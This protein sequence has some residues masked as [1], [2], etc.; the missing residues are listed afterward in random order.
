MN[1]PEWSFKSKENWD[2]EKQAI[3]PFHIE[4]FQEALRD[5]VRAAGTLAK[6][7]TLKCEA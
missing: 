4:K 3:G 5:S 1:V 7:P 6:Q 2:G